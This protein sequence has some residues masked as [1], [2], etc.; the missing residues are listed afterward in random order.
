MTRDEFNEKWQAH[1]EPRHYG[2]SIGNPQVIEYMDNEFTKEVEHNPNFTYAQIK[3]KFGMARV[4]A[5][6]EQTG[7]WERWIDDLYKTK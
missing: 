5:T 2:M 4:Y 6:S 1:L 3:L 7:V